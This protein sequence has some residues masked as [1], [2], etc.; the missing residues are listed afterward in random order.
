MYGVLFSMG[1]KRRVYARI[2]AD[3]WPGFLGLGFGCRMV[4][5]RSVGYAF[6]VGLWCLNYRLLMVISFVR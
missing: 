6:G 1:R 4:K 2:F 5:E 3:Y